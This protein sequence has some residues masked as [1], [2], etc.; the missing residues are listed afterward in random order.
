MDP[1]PDAAK[2]DEN[3]EDVNEVDAVEILPDNDDPVLIGF[4]RFIDDDDEGT[5]Y[6]NT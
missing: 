1:D 3:D 5:L 2:V 6:Y 4:I